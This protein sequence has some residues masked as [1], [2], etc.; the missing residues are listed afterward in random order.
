MRDPARAQ[1]L[2]DRGVRV[3]HGDFTDGTTLE[4]AFEGASRVLVV[5]VDKLGPDAVEMHRTAIDSA[6]KAG[7]ERIVYTS[8]MGADPS[9]PFAPAPDHAAA[10]AAMRDTGVPFTSLRNGF[11]ASSLRMLVAGAAHTGELAMPAD[12]P[13]AW[14]GHDDLAEAA[15]IALTGDQLT[16]ITPPLTG[17]EAADMAEVAGLMGVRRVVVTD[18]EYVA[19]LVANGMPEHA[20]TL[21]LGMFEASR[22]G[23]FAPADPALARLLGRPPVPLRDLLV[24]PGDPQQ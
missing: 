15:V 2:A 13:V 24:L 22:R 5:S 23:D 17:A 20:A 16:G 3:R 7:A 10:E 9:S 6:A 19:G 18:E 4:H 11:Y 14:T 12:G 1:D 8:H 21:F